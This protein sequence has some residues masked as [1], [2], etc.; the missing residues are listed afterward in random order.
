ML[1]F[2]SETWNLTPTAVKCLEGIQLRAAWRMARIHKPKQAMEE[3]TGI[4]TWTYPPSKEV[5]E[6]YG[7]YP[8]THYI[9]VRRQHIASFFV[10]W[11]IFDLCEGGER[12][13]GLLPA[14]TG[15]S[16]RLTWV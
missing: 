2:D 14:N 5:M 3:G 4:V 7:L 12:I 6:E 8:M 11:P 1:L 13:C 9:E 16:N 15:G 10:H